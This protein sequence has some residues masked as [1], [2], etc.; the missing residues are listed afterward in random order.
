[1]SKNLVNWIIFIFLS[2]VW[3]SSFILMKVGLQGLTSLQVAAIRISSGGLFFLPLTLKYIRQIPRKEI[4]LVFLSGTIGNLI[5]ALLFCLAEEGIDSALTGT[6][7][8]LTPVFVIITGTLFFRTK[9]SV[10][11]I[12][13]IGIAL[14]GSVLLFMSNGSLQQQSKEISFALFVVLATLLYGFNVNFVGRRLHHLGSLKIASVALSLN[15]ILAFIVLVATG[16]FSLPL[17]NEA[18][19]M[20]TGA[21]VLL[22]VLGTAIATALFY[23]LVKR[24]G[25]IFATMVTYGMPFVAIAWGIYFDEQFGWKQVGCLL[26]ILVGVYLANKRKPEAL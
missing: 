5:P 4:L 7:N 13:G 14:F 10:D 18:I 24:A 17:S 2:V 11:K 22:G 21:S 26:V 25:A 15:G 6:L 19:L 9:T 16:Y 3:G 1:M 23:V 12:I 8:S 20:S